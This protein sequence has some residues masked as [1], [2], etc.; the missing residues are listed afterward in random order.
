MLDFSKMFDDFSATNDGGNAVKLVYEIIPTF[1]QDQLEILATLNYMIRR[2]DLKD[3]EEFKAVVEYN[4]KRNKNLDF[5]QHGAIKSMLKALTM[6]ELVK[7]IKP[8][9]MHQQDE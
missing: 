6:E 9:V 7:G 4:Q 1:S 5:L 3:L 8:Q 2:Y